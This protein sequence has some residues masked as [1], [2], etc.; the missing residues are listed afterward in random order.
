MLMQLYRQGENGTEQCFYVETSEPLTQ[1][2]KQ[3]I[4]WLATETF[5]PTQTR[6]ESFLTP[7]HALEIGPRLN[8]ETPFSSNAVAICHAMGLTKVTRIEQSRRYRLSDSITEEAISASCLDQMTQV[9]YREPV[10]TFDQNIAPQSTQIVSVLEH[11]TDALRKLNAELGLGMDDWDIEFYVNLFV[12]YGRNPTDVELFQIGNANSEHSRHWFF[13]GKLIIDGLEM[14]ESLFNIVR[15]PLR[16]L[17][18]SNSILAFNDN[19][20]VI[21]GS[22]IVAFLPNHPGHPASFILREGVW[23][24]ACTAETH[25]HP[26][27][28]APYP[29]AETGSGGRI[30]DNAA[31]GRGALPFAGVAGYCVGNL[32]LIDHQIP[33]EN[34]GGEEMI[35]YASSVRILI[36]STIKATGLNE[37]EAMVYLASLKLGPDTVNH[38]AKEAK[39]KR[40]TTY[41]I[42][43]QLKEKTVASIKKTKRATHYSVIRPTVL[44]ERF[45]KQEKILEKALPELEKLHKEQL[46]KPKIEVFE[47]VDGVNYIYEDMEKYLT[48]KEGVWYYGSLAQ[49]QEKEYTDAHDRWTELMK[50]PKNRAREIV[51]RND[52]KVFDYYKKNKNP[53]HQIR[54]MPKGLKFSD[55][56][57]AIY[58][59]KLAILSAKKELFVVIIES[60]T[61]AESYRNFYELAWKSSKPVKK[62]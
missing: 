37:K 16:T 46:H 57:N 52:I 58:G 42:L 36:E 48:S 4:V 33:G 43:E 14:P 39:I 19:A 62:Y 54:M 30:R 27:L 8:V 51:D 18:N 12:R 28:I 23:H 50:N 31:P 59:N 22:N 56:D 53:N 21:R 25:N 38:I 1:Q 29:G 32:F 15:T 55:N 26:T 60:E 17:G 7:G 24:V 47:G 9:I 45:K 44:L 6:F 49:F 10:T 34:I 40:T 41:F 35:R 13:R 11:G 20:G 5:E 3:R 61:I 2:E